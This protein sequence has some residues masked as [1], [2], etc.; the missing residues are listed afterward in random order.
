MR[1]KHLLL[2]A[3]AASTAL[4]SCSKSEETT[5]ATDPNVRKNVSVTIANQKSADAAGPLS[6]AVATGGLTDKTGSLLVADASELSALCADAGGNILHVFKLGTDILAEADTKVPS[7]TK[8]GSTYTFHRLNQSVVKIAFTN[9]SNVNAVVGK[10]LAEAK[11]ALNNLITQNPVGGDLHKILVYG[12]STKFVLVGEDEH[13]DGAVYSYYDAG[14]VT[15]NPILARIEV[16]G[17]ACS[18]L[19]STT[20]EEPGLLPKYSELTL[21]RIGI[22]DT[23]VDVVG[24][25]K[26]TNNPGQAG[27]TAWLGMTGWNID[28][29][30]TDVLT[31]T[32]P[33]SSKVYV[34][35]VDPN[36][37]PKIILQ[38]NGGKWNTNIAGVDNSK[39]SFPVYVKTSELRSGGAALTKLDPQKIYQIKLEFP[40]SAV[41]PWLPTLEICVDVE[42]VIPDWT[43]VD[44]IEVT[45]M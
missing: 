34:Y 31:Q 16:Y 17:I 30:L 26:V 45:Y 20:E 33:G 14:T 19:N 10:T 7:A 43:V 27:E 6:R 15:V 4:A 22:L 39:L 13:T 9:T 12:E 36:S 3:L 28:E 8:N 41:K 37:L 5:T 18:N 35:N 38:I 40:C 24:G 1:I 42:V 29:G 44:D 21:G 2:T 25:T 11:A 23:P 32:A